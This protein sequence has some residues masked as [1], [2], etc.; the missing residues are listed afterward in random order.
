MILFYGGK[1]E[2]HVQITK[3]FLKDC[4]IRE[5]N[6]S[7]LDYTMGQLID[8]NADLDFSAGPTDEY[9]EMFVYFTEDERDQIIPMFQ[10]F[11]QQ[12]LAH[13]IAAVETPNNLKMTLKEELNDLMAEERYYQKRNRLIEFVENVQPQRLEQDGM[14]REFAMFV[15]KML[16][17]EK[18]PQEMLDELV[19]M[20]EKVESGDLA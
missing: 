19:R 7:L 14:Y 8:P 3:Q 5:L 12:G 20:V 15:F 17:Q 13:P 9:D 1:K 18:M 2:T 10:H 4:V 16:Q 11:E 6:D